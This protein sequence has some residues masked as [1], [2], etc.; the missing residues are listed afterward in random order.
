MK[1]RLSKVRALLRIVERD[2]PPAPPK[3]LALFRDFAEW[4]VSTS[5]QLTVSDYARR[6]SCRELDMAF[7]IRA[8]AVRNH[9]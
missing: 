2:E 5:P 8:R 6:K 4:N 7:E 1:P 3:V 9:R